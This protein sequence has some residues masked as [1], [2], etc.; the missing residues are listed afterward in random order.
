MVDWDEE[1]AADL[2]LEHM[3]RVGLPLTR[4]SWLDFNY[5]DGAPDPLHPELAAAVPR[6]LRDDDEVLH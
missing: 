1:F 4:R 6:W 3:K 5:P 2:V